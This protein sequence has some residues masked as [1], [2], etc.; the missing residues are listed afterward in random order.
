MPHPKRRQSASRRDKRRTHDS[1]LMPTI[2][3]CKKTGACHLGHNIY[4][5]EGIAYYRGRPIYED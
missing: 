2:Y 5:H 4:K 1:I 3:T